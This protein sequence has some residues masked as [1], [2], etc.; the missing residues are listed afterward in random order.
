MP[1]AIMMSYDRVQVFRF[2]DGTDWVATRDVDE[3]IKWYC[4]EN[5]FEDA[6]DAGFDPNPV[7]LMTEHYIEGNNPEAGRETFLD[8]IKIRIKNGWEFPAVISSENF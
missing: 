8:C 5:G 2:G 3:A 4:A 1:P 6:D 7:C